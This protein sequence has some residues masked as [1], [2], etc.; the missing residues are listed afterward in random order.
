MPQV[1]VKLRAIPA[2]T[3]EYK[4]VDTQRGR[5]ADDEHNVLARVHIALF[6]DVGIDWSGGSGVGGLGEVLNCYG[7]HGGSRC[8]EYQE[9][10]QQIHLKHSENVSVNR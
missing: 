2:C 6:D 4:N 10:T 5:R 9:H 3:S 7:Q 1:R 8:S